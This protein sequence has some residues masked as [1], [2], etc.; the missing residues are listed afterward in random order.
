M[1]RVEHVA[2]PDA[3]ARN[4]ALP[5]RVTST[6]DSCVKLQMLVYCARWASRCCEFPGMARSID[7]DASDFRVVTWLVLTPIFSDTRPH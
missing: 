4:P 3:I 5:N 7:H 1:S 6:L 2:A